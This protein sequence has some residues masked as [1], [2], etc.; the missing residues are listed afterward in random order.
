MTQDEKHEYLEQLVEAIYEE[1]KRRNLRIYEM[2]LDAMSP[3][4][5]ATLNAEN[6]KREIY[7]TPGCAQI[8]NGE[9]FPE[10]GE[11][12]IY[13][14]F[15]TDDGSCDNEGILPYTLTFNSENDITKYFQILGRHLSQMTPTT[16][17]INLEK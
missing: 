11:I 17:T 13:I 10:N 7:C 12:G 14:E 3:C 6:P 9:D 15:S 1:S 8:I 5:Y 4:L 2:N 16:T